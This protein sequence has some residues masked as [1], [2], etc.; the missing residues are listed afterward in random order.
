MHTTDGPRAEVGAAPAVA[1]SYFTP[2]ARSRMLNYQK[3]GHGPRWCFGSVRDLAF[4]SALSSI[5][6]PYGPE[7]L[8]R[9]KTTRARAL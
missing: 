2:G 9:R 8:C 3:P 4:N 6:T 7:A 5:A 1:M